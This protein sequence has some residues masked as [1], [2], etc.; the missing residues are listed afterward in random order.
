MSSPDLPSNVPDVALTSIAEAAK[1]LDACDNIIASYPGLLVRSAASQVLNLFE[2]L[3]RAISAPRG[4]PCAYEVCVAF[5][6]GI[7]AVLSR[8]HPPNPKLHHL[9]TAAQGLRTELEL[10][11]GDTYG[12]TQSIL[13][14]KKSKCP[15]WSVVVKIGFDG[16]G[17]CAAALFLGCMILLSLEDK[18][19]SRKSLAQKLDALNSVSAI[20]EDQLSKALAGEKVDIIGLDDEISTLRRLWVKVIEKFGPGQSPTPSTPNE[21]ARAQVLSAA[22]N[23][24]A[25]HVAGAA[26]H[27]LLTEEQFRRV[28]ECTRV[29]VLEDTLKGS[30]AVLVMRTGLSVDLVASMP[31]ITAT[32]TSA[33]FGLD[34]SQATVV[35]DLRVLAHEAGKPLPGSLPARYCLE[36]HLPAILREQLQRRLARHSSAK[37][38]ADLYPEASTPNALANVCPGVE[39]IAPT[40][41]RLRY[42][43]GYA[44]RH[45]GINKLLVALVCGDFGIIPRSKLHYARVAAPEFH[46]VEQLVYT[47]LGLGES[48][49]ILDPDAP[50]IGCGVV[51]APDNIQR[52]DEL[53]VCAVQTSRPG[54]AGDL[55]LLRSFHNAYT[56][57]IAWRLS[58]LLALR[59]TQIIEL[60]A[61]IDPALDTWVPV[62]DKRTDRDRGFQPVALC[63]Y[64]AMTVMLYQQHCL[65]TG[66]RA[67]RLAGRSTEFSLW[68]ESVG[69]RHN[70]RLLSFVT[71]SDQVKGVPSHAFTSTTSFLADSPAH[72]GEAPYVLAPDV[73]RKVMENELRMQGA[74][75]SDID[76]HLRHFVQG[77]EPSSAFDTSVLNE[78]IPRIAAAQQRVAV[79]LLGPPEVGLSKGLIRR[80]TLEGAHK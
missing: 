69:H 33:D 4:S 50:G 79:S 37:S 17:N 40:W 74:R 8:L 76:A 31:L 71:G 68:C 49:G 5:I 55:P 19:A 73:G 45:Q 3:S 39:E 54:K 38:L 22:L 60:D 2:S 70:V 66:E 36:V 59:E 75:S 21:R 58:V 44:L 10:K 61:G 35:L 34:V 30:L 9:L 43:L 56:A 27:R 63:A 28:C 23:C 26:S 29:E 64:A 11:R 52:H 65:A 16:P 18:K 42:S 15:A 57:L 14:G 20:S 6:D 7:K 77:Q 53:L 67:A 32:A 80:E 78:R 72:V 51:P 62:H 25:S 48:S 12:S 41:S 47:Q 46:A 24:G 1:D 13:K